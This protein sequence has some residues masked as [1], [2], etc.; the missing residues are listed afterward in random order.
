MTGDWLWDPFSLMDGIV[1]EYK[2]IKVLGKRE[3]II[4]GRKKRVIPTITCSSPMTLTYG[5]LTLN[6]PA[7]KTKV[8]E[9][10]LGEGEHAL[11]FSGNGTVSVSYRGGSL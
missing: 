6:L 10:Q 11:E 7:G 2:D 3:I 4:A 1:R 5:K 9:L 8:Y